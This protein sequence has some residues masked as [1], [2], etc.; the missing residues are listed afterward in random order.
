MRQTVILMLCSA[1]T[2]GVFR[3]TDPIRRGLKKNSISAS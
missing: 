1:L 2:T 3:P